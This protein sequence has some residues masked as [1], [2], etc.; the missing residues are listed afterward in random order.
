M[1]PIIYLTGA[2]ATI[3]AAATVSLRFAL[4]TAGMVCLWTW[5][6]MVNPNRN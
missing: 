2:L 3:A 5:R 6:Q 1:T 4:F